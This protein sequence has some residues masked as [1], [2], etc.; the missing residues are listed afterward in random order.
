MSD[1]PSATRPSP[2]PAGAPWLLVRLPVADVAA[3][4]DFYQAALGFTLQQKLDGPDGRPF[5]AELRYH[6]AVVMLGLED[7]DTRTP[8]HRGG[9]SA[10]QYLYVDP[11]DEVFERA[12]DAGARPV[13][14]PHNAFWGDRCA[15]IAD[16]DGHLW[17]LAAHLPNYDAWRARRA[18]IADEQKPESD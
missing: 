4:I 1:H 10:S 18:Q 15:L 5:H 6:D 8:A 17:T 14:S 9:A 11:I 12:L 16:P 7:G 3:A 2:R 13:R